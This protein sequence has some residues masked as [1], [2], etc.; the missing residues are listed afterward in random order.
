MLSKEKVYSAC[1]QLVNEKVIFLKQT[2]ADLTE[3]GESDAKSSAGD[4][5]ETARAM[6]QAEQEKLNHQLGE[7]MEQKTMLDKINP[8]IPL[9]RIGLGAFIKTD[10]GYLFL[11]VALGKIK[12]DGAEVITL[13][14][15]SPL[16][17]K[18]MGLTVNQSVQINTTTYLVQEIS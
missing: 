15:A 11:S 1:L 3:G 12:V 18:L 14:P 10:K 17:I 16:G 5:H 6:L 9:D 7:V 4:K 2:I 8:T 13:S